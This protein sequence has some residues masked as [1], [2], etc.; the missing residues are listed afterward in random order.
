MSS[1]SFCNNINAKKALFEIRVDNTLIEIDGGYEGESSLY[2][3][4]AKNNISSV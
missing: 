1:S 4:E 2:L 3:I